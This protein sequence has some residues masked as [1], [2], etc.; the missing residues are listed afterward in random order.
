MARCNIPHQ[1]VVLRKANTKLVDI[2]PNWGVMVTLLDV[3]VALSVMVAVLKVGGAVVL[4][5]LIL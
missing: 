4:L 1:C 2:T 5:V 3:V